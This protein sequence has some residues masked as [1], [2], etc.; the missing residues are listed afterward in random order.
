MWYEGNYRCHQGLSIFLFLIR[1]LQIP[2]FDLERE[3]AI[4]KY[5]MVP[6]KEL[7][8]PKRF[9]FGENITNTKLR[10]WSWK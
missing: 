1:L 8:S 7:D 9:D 2:T 6:K 3:R 4:Y 5:K 10:A